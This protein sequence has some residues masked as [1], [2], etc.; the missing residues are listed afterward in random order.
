MKSNMYETQF[1]NLTVR[2]PAGW[3]DIKETLQNSVDF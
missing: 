1:S 2:V 3:I